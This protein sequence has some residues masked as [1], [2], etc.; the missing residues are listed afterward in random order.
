MVRRCQKV[1]GYRPMPILFNEDDHA[2]FA[3]PA[4]NLLAALREYASWGFL[5]QGRNNYNDGFQSPPVN[6][7]INT[8]RKR[9]FF[10]LLKQITGE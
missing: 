4:N 7:A 9:S 8:E 10:N 1:E 5:D 3:Q 6:W 2:D